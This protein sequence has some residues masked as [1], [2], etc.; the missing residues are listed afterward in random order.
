M[1]YLEET[2]NNIL[3]SMIMEMTTGS[4]KG[5]D[6]M[7]G[8]GGDM[9]EIFGTETYYD[10]EDDFVGPSGR[11]IE[12]WDPEYFFRYHWKGPNGYGEGFPYWHEKFPGGVDSWELAVEQWWR[13]LY[14]DAQNDDNWDEQ[15]DDGGWTHPIRRYLPYGP[16][17]VERMDTPPYIRPIQGGGAGDEG[18]GGD[19]GLRPTIGPAGLIPATRIP[20]LIRQLGKLPLW[21][22]LPAEVAG[23]VGLETMNPE[24]MDELPSVFDLYDIIP[25]IVPKWM[26]PRDGDGVRP[27]K[28]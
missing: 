22:S 19:I 28:M 15:D 26:H 5:G 23:E 25:K 27:Y 16:Q 11:P 14:E 6:D 8:G 3:R 4:D 10:A 21:Q 7:M 24:L 12:S 2:T 18:G 9:P 13:D 1:R 20:G 17:G